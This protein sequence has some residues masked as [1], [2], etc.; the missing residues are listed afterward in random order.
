MYRLIAVV[1][2]T[3]SVLEILRQIC[4]SLDVECRSHSIA[5]LLKTI[6]N[7]LIEIIQSKQIP[8]LIIDEA[9]LIRLEVFAQMHTIGQFDMDSKPVM[10]VILSGQNNLIG[11]LMYH[12]SR[13]IASRA[14]GHILL[15]NLM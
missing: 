3:G 10:P 4:L 2:G 1:A 13:P 11:N 7:I 14:D 6:K 9:Q 5:T 12:T 8:V 15:V